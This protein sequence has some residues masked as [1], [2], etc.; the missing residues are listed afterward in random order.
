MQTKVP[1]LAPRNIV[2]PID[3]RANVAHDVLTYTMAP[4][5]TWHASLPIHSWF[6]FRKSRTGSDELL[7][8]REQDGDGKRTED[9]RGVEVWPAF[10]AA[11]DYG[12]AREAIHKARGVARA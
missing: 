5:W 11:S 4:S 2:E 3:L 9:V 10:V 12:A 7:C 6:G 1:V 8:V